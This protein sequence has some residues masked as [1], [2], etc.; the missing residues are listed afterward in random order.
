MPHNCVT[1]STAALLLIQPGSLAKHVMLQLGG[2]Y[3]EVGR[4][5]SPPSLASALRPL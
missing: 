2:S 3:T 1:L 4:E 5:G